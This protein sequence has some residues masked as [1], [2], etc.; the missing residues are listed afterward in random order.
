MLK[1]NYNMKSHNDDKKMSKIHNDKLIEIEG[2]FEIEKTRSNLMNYLE[3]LGYELSEKDLTQN[4]QGSKKELNVFVDGKRYIDD[5]FG[6][7]VSF[8]L[9]M[10]GTDVEVM[11]NGKPVIKSKGKAQLILSAYLE[12]D[13]YMKR[14]GLSGF[15]KFWFNLYL[16]LHHEH[17]F[18]DAVI[19]VAVE[20]GGILKF[21]KKECNSKI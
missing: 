11:E 8:R 12:E 19:K 10:S 4:N 6:M 21:F 3:T 18:A 9:N 2:I 14:K 13:P 20:S 7:W 16:K 5:Y 15:D 17:M 1:N